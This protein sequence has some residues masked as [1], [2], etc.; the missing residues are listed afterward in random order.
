MPSLTLLNDHDSE[1]INGG[2]WGSYN[3]SSFSYKSVTTNL[4]QSNTANNLGVGL[5]YGFGNA[6]SEQ[7]NLS[8]IS[9]FIG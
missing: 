9:S 5:L 4:T 6:T 8:G 7:V 2:W 1:V 3:I